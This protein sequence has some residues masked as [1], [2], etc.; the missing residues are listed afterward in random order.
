M[1]AK[2]I[3]KYLGIPLCLFLFL[4]AISGILLN[5]RDLLQQV[6]I[7]RSI[8]PSEYKF[9]RWNNGAVRGILR[10]DSIAY[11]YGGAGIWETDSSLQREARSLHAGFVPGGDE[12]KVMS[13]VQDR[14]G[15]IWA[16]SQFRLYRL[17]P[18]LKRW[19]EQPLPTSV[20]GRLA[21]LQISGDS[22]LLLSRSLLYVR[23]LSNP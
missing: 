8:L 7:P 2:K 5:H 21:D 11:I 3:H 4:A 17:D 20:Q 18:R 16:A 13:M 12:A 1:K 19:S 23:T 14:S 6:D 10:T 9:E 22:I 15:G